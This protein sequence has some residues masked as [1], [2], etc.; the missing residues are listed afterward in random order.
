MNR[1]RLRLLSPEGDAGGAG[2]GSQGAGAGSQDS[3][4]GTGSNAGGAAG[5]AGD[6]QA[7]FAQL[8]KELKAANAEAAER[9]VKLTD[10]EKAEQARKEEELKKQN[11]LQGLLN[12]REKELADAKA[13][14]TELDATKKALTELEESRRKEIG[15]ASC[16]ERVYVL[17]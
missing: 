2:A 5:N 17:V 9:R 6:L 1:F 12:I 7:R 10:Y 11:D 14:L 15:R 13:Q 16:R 4:T 3:G 8:E